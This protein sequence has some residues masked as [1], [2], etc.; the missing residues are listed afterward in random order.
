MAEIY[1][2]AGHLIETYLTEAAE[3][4]LAVGCQ[5]EVDLDAV[6]LAVGCLLLMG[7]LSVTSSAFSFSQ[8]PPSLSSP[9][10]SIAAL[11][12]KPF[13]KRRI[14]ASSMA[15]ST[16]STLLTAEGTTA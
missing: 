11:L 13:P 12:S 7:R 3:D 5:E 1:L 10:P 14:V 6:G 15:T 4:Y 2:A 8:L 16:P 9:L